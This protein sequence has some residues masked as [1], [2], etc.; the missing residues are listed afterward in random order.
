MK[1]VFES[2]PRADLF[3]VLDAM[4]LV[5]AAGCLDQDVA[6][7]LLAHVYSQLDVSA[8]PAC[9]QLGFKVVCNL[10]TDHSA[11]LLTKYREVLVAKVNAILEEADEL[12]PALQVALASVALNYAVVYFN[13]ADTEA[14]VQLVSALAT[15]YVSR[16]NAPEALYRAAIALGTLVVKDSEARDLA[17]ALDAACALGALAESTFAFPAA[18]HRSFTAEKHSGGVAAKMS[19]TRSA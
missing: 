14:S 2:W 7:E 16:L 19:A 3:P 13:D 6:K 11:P 10:F 1:S 4:R 12:P 8:S 17:L 18:M 5:A 15:T 9:L